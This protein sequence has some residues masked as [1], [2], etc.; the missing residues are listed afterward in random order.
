[1]SDDPRVGTTLAGYHI[2]SLIGR[3]GMS[4]VY[5]AEQDFPKRK[6]A[7]KLLS[8]DLARDPKFRER[9]VRESNLAA[10]IEHPNIIPIYGAGDSEG[11]LYIAMRYIGGG[12]L[13][14]LIESEGH[15]PPE[16]AMSIVGQVAGALDAAHAAGLVHR[17]VKPSNILLGVRAGPSSPDHAYLSDFGLTKRVLSDSGI[18]GTGVFVGTLDYAAPEQFEGKTLDGRTD[19][20]SLGCVLFECLTGEL[21]YQRDQDAAL[22]YA[23]LMAPAPSITEKRPEL[24]KAIDG[25]I[26]KAM[27]KAPADRYATAGELV[28]AARKALDLSSGEHPVIPPGDLATTGARRFSPGRLVALALALIVGIV[29]GI[30]LLGRGG[31]EPSAVASGTPTAPGQGSASP[32]SS[33]AVPGSGTLVRIELAT[34][35]VT[36]SIPVGTHPAGVAVGEGSVWVTNSG[37]G[38]VSRID[39]VTNTV[40]ATIEVGRGPEGIAFG[41]GSVWVANRFSNTVSRIDPA[42]N[43]VTSISV[44]SPPGDIGVGDGSVWAVG[45]ARCVDTFTTPV[46]RIDPTTNR[47]V[48]SLTVDGCSLARGFEGAGAMW[49]VTDN[50]N[51][52]RIDLQTSLATRV[53]QL[54]RSLT[55]IVI[56]NDAV[57]VATSGFPGVVLRIDPETSRVEAT[58]PAGGSPDSSTAVGIALDAQTVWVIDR[59]NGLVSPIVVSGNDAQQPVQV[60]KDATAIADGLG[61]VWVTVAAP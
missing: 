14:A 11:L 55:G 27:A 46:Y 37:D 10:S 56:G 31:G 24:P 12:D 57:W 53:T 54:H 16:R 61:A 44:D 36:A 25:V 40:T 48:A 38:T 6:V 7:L 20:Y 15:L 23:H 17:D 42:T 59:N 60:G 2:E 45:H 34:R 49:T 1:M 22:M 28:A 30:V 35:R 41:E 8:T 18:T 32:S 33:V 52:T 19:V 13:K 5:L 26:A 51:L 58:I 4:V 3:G 50:G 43:Q 29:V 21:P 39:P 47:V 9:F